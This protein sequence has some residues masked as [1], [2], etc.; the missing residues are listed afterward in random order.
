MTSGARDVIVIG[1]GIVGCQTA[2]LL[3]K[4][5]LSV[6]ILEADSVASHASGFAFGE[7]GVLEGA[8][9]PDPLLDFTVWSHQ[10]H[11]SLAAELQ[12]TSGVDPQFQLGGRIKLALTEDDASAFKQ[13][14]AWQK[15]IRELSPTWL[16]AGD[17]LKVEPQVNPRCIGG[18]LVRKSGSVEPYRYTL[19]AAQSAEKLG[20]D[21]VL[22]RAVGLTSEGGR[23]VGVLTEDGQLSAGAFVLA[24]GPWTGEASEWC[25]V[26]LPVTPLKGQILRLKHPSLEVKSSIFFGG[27][28]VASKPDGLIWAGTTE[29]EVGFD[30][31]T[32]P[33]ARDKIMADL[34]MMAPN[35]VD[36]EL[37]HQTA[38][39][40]P[41]STDGMP[42][43]GRIPGWEN[44]YVGTGAGRKGILWSSGMSQGLADI[45]LKGE[46][47]VPGAEALDPSRFS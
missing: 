27:S 9:I 6:T 34:L 5:G 40:R 12:E 18:V 2:Y 14:L 44:L 8:G 33:Q 43:V 23:C 15:D 46:S 13:S 19:A 26:D 10:R 47:D 22:R 38:C 16:D 24:M 3:A 41:L 30:E 31:E 45:I 28:Y 25:G 4:S 42:I 21:M 37:V 35:L 20:A 36:T 11:I 1:G 7:M 17:L 32:T 29:E 39:L